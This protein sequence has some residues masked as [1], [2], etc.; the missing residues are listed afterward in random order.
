[1][2]MRLSRRKFMQQAVAAA[3]AT[4][5]LVACDRQIPAEPNSDA[6]PFDE[7]LDFD[8]IGLAGLLRNGDVSQSEMV[9]MMIRR[10]EAT[11]P[12]LNFMT[13]RFYERARNVAGTISMDTPFSGVP[14]LLKD[15]IDLAGMP[16][17][18]GSNFPPNNVPQHSAQYVQGLGRAGFNFLGMTNVP[19]QAAGGGTY[20]LRFG[21]TKN[22]W[23]KDYYPFMSS[24]G[25]AAAVAAGVSP[26]THGTDGGGS[27]RL[28]ASATGLLGMKPSRYRM[29]ADSHDGTHDIAKTNQMISRT[30]RDSAVAFH[31]TQDPNNGHYAAEPLIESASPRRLK[32][33][34]VL[35][36]PGLIET[37]AEVRGAIESSLQRLQELGHTVEEANYPVDL[38]EF[39]GH[40]LNFFA[41]RTAGLKDAIEH[42]TGK[43]LMES[44]VITQFLAGAALAYDQLSEEEIAAGSRYLESLT[45]TF[46]QWFENYDLLVTPVS[47]IAGVRVDEAGVD[48]EFTESSN[49]LVMGVAKFTGP[50]NFSGCPAM[51]VPLAWNSSAGLPIGTHCI[52]ARGDDR[53]L[54]ELAYELEEAYPWKDKW[55][56]NSLRFA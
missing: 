40:Y 18:D 2:T 6:R 42:A 25:A 46:D 9:E 41:S 39:F 56:P 3:V 8:C 32:V 29:L 22:P 14:M 7:F 55:A 28:P 52:A 47:P 37:S 11:N 54:Y 16:R 17:T 26:M 10:I 35:E 34:Y 1:M 49:R 36:N 38:E 33:G 50:I 30:V 23:N 24:G 19:E 53:M 12:A 27:N 43:P 21:A 31:M 45:A 13:N 5:P 48:L 20:N 51:S 44:G 15:M 4:S